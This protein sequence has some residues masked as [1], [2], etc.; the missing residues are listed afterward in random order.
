MLN[1]SSFDTDNRWDAIKSLI[2]IFLVEDSKACLGWKSCSQD[3][4]RT[5]DT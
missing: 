4:H 5:I 2:A 3:G 1:L